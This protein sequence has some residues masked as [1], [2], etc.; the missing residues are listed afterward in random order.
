MTQET[1]RCS[2]CGAEKSL[3]EFSWRKERNAPYKQCKA[4]RNYTQSRWKGEN[5]E[6]Q[7]ELERRFHERN[8]EKRREYASR[9]RKNLREQVLDHYGR[10]CACCNEN[11]PSFLAIDHVENNGAEHRLE[12]NISNGSDLYRLLKREGWPDGFQTLCHNCNFGKHLNGGI[13]PHQE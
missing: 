10:E 11:E 9:W 8:P 5:R 4:C 13:C 6:R 7:R 1:Q 2:R 3:D 12:N